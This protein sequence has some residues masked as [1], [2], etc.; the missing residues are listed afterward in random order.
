[1]HSFCRNLA[2]TVDTYGLSWRGFSGLFIVVSIQVQVLSMHV[3]HWGGG[4]GGTSIIRMLVEVCPFLHEPCVD[5]LIGVC[6]T[7]VQFHGCEV[8]CASISLSLS[9]HPH[10]ENR[11]KNRDV[12][13]MFSY[14][15]SR[16]RH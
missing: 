1:M 8:M 3:Y 9:I 10:R 7:N 5:E 13:S 11:N 16:Y 2:D 15:Y 4:G 12:R 14:Y 6:T